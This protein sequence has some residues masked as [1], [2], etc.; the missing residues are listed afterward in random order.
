MARA[1]TFRI[2]EA[3]G[4]LGTSTDTVRRLTDAGRLRIRRTAA[5]HRVIDGAELA[6]FLTSNRE[7]PAEDVVVARSAR[8][9]FPGI[10]TRVMKD[11]IVA[12]VEIHAGPHRIVSLMTR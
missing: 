1:P 4:V 3:A 10:V 9:S 5:G 6:R 7:S 12:H 11:K 2:G 8:N